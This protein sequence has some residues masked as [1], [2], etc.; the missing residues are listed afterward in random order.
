MVDENEKIIATEKTLKGSL[1]ISNAKL[2]WPYLMNDNP[3]YQYILRVRQQYLIFGVEKTKSVVS[4]FP[5]ML[6]AL[7]HFWK[8]LFHRCITF[9][10]L[11]LI[12]NNLDKFM[13]VVSYNNILKIY[14]VK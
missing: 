6:T 5:P 9:Q 8:A 10:S 7:F 4:H 1:K 13:Q 3:G 14:E 11:K 2:W 12:R